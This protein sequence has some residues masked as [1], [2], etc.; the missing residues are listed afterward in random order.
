MSAGERRR[1]RPLSIEESELWTGV[2]RSV[3]PLRGRKRPAADPA[4]ETFAT[5]AAAAGPKPKARP[6][7]AA[8]PPAPP[9]R[10]TANPAPADAPPLD[11]RSRK[12]ILR[13]GDPIDARLDLHGLT[14][15]G[16]HARLAQFLQ[17]CQ[18]QGLRTVLVVTGKGAAGDGA[19]RGVLRR[20]VPHWLALPEFRSVIAGFSEAGPAHGGAG[21]LYL[22]LK[23]RRASG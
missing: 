22:R 18:G 16:A 12:R 3:K 5:P 6:R 7:P 20:Q 11:P 21:A 9:L 13:G 14:Q 19:G 15:A 23:R 10:P 17:S 8:A 4:M 1:G 2:T